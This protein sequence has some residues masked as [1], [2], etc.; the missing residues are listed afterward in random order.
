MTRITRTYLRDRIA[1]I[2]KQYGTTFALDCANWGY[3]ITN[4]DGSRDYSNR[5]TA[6]EA[7][8]FLSG[9]LIELQRIR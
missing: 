3:K 5:L 1:K 2:N 8:A 7:N 6:S 9:A 4:H